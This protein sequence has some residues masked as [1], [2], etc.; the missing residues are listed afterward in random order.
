MIPDTPPIP[1]SPE[2]RVRT[3]ESDIAAVGARGGE[4]IT[5]TGGRVVAPQGEMYSFAKG[6]P[7]ELSNVLSPRLLII[8]G[9]FAIVLLVGYLLYSFFY[10]FF[11]GRD[12]PEGG[13]PPISSA[14]PPRTELPPLVPD[15]EPTAT[16]IT[17]V[18]FF[19]LAPGESVE[20]TARTGPATS[21]ENLQ[22][23]SQ[24]FSALAGRMRESFGEVLVRGENGQLAAGDFFSRIDAALLPP[25]FLAE[26]FNQDFTA[27]MYKDAKG[28]WPGYVLQ[29]KKSATPVLVIPKINPAIESAA[30]EKIA[31]L[32]LAPPAVPSSPAF[33]DVSIDEKPFRILSFG[34][35]IEFIYGWFNNSLLV[36][37]T[38]RA[39]L[40][41]A[42]F[43]LGR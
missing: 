27:F 39:G 3:M 7:R 31:N 37:S 4:V 22:T 13:A 36:L 40:E 8:I 1:S 19:R 25:D 26:N 14:V 30:P 16:T 32:Y 10:P 12:N 20:L 2:I 38:S 11:A 33:K 35:G 21:A 24:R 42:F 28:A 5:G 18:S 43:Y 15:L 6:N 41:K 23:F 17:H 34:K 9:V 29:L